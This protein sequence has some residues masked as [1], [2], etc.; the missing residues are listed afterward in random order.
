MRKKDEG[1]KRGEGK[2]APSCCETRVTPHPPLSLCL[3][4]SLTFRE[5]ERLREFERQ[6]RELERL[7]REKK[8]QE[9]AEMRRKVKSGR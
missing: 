8:E 2:R 6:Q 9:A 7:E 3:S 1:K 4:L 5:E